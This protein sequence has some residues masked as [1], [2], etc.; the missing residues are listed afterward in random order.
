L[1]NSLLLSLIKSGSLYLRCAI[2]VCKKDGGSFQ[3]SINIS[4][5]DVFNSL[6]KLYQSTK[7]EQIR[8]QIELITQRLNSIKV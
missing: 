4:I 1:E 5:T 2:D 3:K 6:E 7:T 8:L